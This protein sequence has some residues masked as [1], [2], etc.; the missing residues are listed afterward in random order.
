MFEI[1]NQSFK[2]NINLKYLL[3][4]GDN[5]KAEKILKLINDYNIQKSVKVLKQIPF[6]EMPRIYSICDIYLSHFNFFKKW[7]HNNS[8]KHLEYL[9][10]GK[11]VV[12]T[13]VG[14]VNFAIENDKNGYLCKEGEIE[15]YVS[16]IKILSKDKS[17]RKKFGNAG[18]LKAINEL[19]W[20]ANIDRIFNFISYLDAKNNL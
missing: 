12:A 1:I 19:S 13:Q 7:P 3:V 20:E 16:A 10:M 15:E 8:I 2:K 14:E 17:L 4:V 6:K 9:A 5:N 11:P 18:R